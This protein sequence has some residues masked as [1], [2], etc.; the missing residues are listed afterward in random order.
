MVTYKDVYI[1][2][3]YSLEDFDLMWQMINFENVSETWSLII[4]ERET[5]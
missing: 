3:I 4:R 5:R 2:K 1:N